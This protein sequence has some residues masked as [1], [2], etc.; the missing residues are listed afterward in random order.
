[1][2]R[3]YPGLLGPKDRDERAQFKRN[4][5]LRHLRQ[6]LWSN[7]EILQ[8]VMGVASRQAAHKSLIMMERDQLLRRHTYQALGGPVTI[9]GITAHGQSM[10]F[11]PATETAFGVYFEPGRISEQSIRHQLELQ[12]LRLGAEAA[13]WS[14][15]V[16]GDRLAVL[17]T[18]GQRPD[19]LALDT[20]L[21]KCAIECERTMK[22]SKRYQSI[23]VGY[24]RA[25][26][27]A[28]IERVI[29]V[30]PTADF[31]RRLRAI[32]TGISKVSIGGQTIMI[33]PLKH[34]LKLQFTDYSRWP[35]E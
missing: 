5:V 17:P 33:D 25:L 23:L 29:W 7:Q 11:D 22:T 16:D 4:A 20:Q 12:R 9:W 34:H 19:A 14:N 1:M 31:S 32:V 26:K 10:A 27:S 28:E 15:W 24:L 3:S 21:R 35:L 6:H 30:S 2:T 18:G 8:Q 13:G